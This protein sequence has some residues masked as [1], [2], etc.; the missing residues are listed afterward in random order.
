LSLPAH[1]NGNG[2]PDLA[3]ANSGDNTVTVLM[4]TANPNDSSYLSQR[5][6]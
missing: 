1:F 4:P 3:I 6:A 2:T 5:L